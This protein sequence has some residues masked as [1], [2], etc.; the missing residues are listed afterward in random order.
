MGNLAIVLLLLCI[1]SSCQ[2][3]DLGCEFHRYCD[4]DEVCYNGQCKVIRCRDNSV[5]PGIVT[6]QD[7]VCSGNLEEDDKHYKDALPIR[8]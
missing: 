6:C 8:V 2:S 5:C 1:V 4:D 3:T 7:G